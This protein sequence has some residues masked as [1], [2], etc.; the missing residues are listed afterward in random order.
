MKIEIQAEGLI[1]DPALQAFVK[2]R[3][4]YA[5]ATFGDQIESVQVRLV[6]VDEA[7]RG[8]DKSCRVQVAFGRRFKAMVEA[9]DTDLKVAVHRAVDRAGWTVSRKL[10]RERRQAV[11]LRNR[12]P[13]APAPAGY[14]EPERAA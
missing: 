1:P 8:R 3:L 13:R 5:L 10:Q 9:M 2:R 14:P 4:G 7:L 12:I 11:A 6:D